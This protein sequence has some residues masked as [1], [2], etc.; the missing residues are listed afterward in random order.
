MGTIGYSYGSEWHLLRLL[1]YH[2]DDL[3]RRIEEVVPGGRI[4]R[5]LP[6]RYETD[7]ARVDRPPLSP[8]FEPRSGKFIHPPRLLDAELEGIGFLPDETPPG[9]RQAWAD[10]WPRRGKQQHWDAVGRIDVGGE[11][12]W[13]LVEAKSHLKEV[14]SECKASERGG[15]SKIREAFRSTAAHMGVEAEAE[16]WMAPY[17]QYANRLAVLSFLIGHGVKAK[18]L[19]IYFLGDRFPE[20]RAEICPETEQ[21]WASQLDAMERRIGWAPHNPLAPHVHKLFLPVC[22]PPSESTP[23]HGESL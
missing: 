21:G 13:L 1:G 11:V 22:P 5:W 20:G 10:Y 3:D 14:A 15:R 17:Y 19:F 23:R 2:R 6:A 16:L 18:L 12:Y 7:A 9:V 4:L 8:V